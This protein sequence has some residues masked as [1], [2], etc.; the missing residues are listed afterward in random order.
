MCKQKSDWFIAAQTG[1]LEYM[2][3][4]IQKNIQTYDRRESDFEAEIFN[5]FSALHYA[6][7]NRY[8]DLVKLLLPFESTLETKQQVGID[9]PGFCMSGKLRVPPGLNCLQLSVLA[10]NVQIIELIM[11]YLKAEPDVYSV[12]V[13]SCTPYPQFSVFSICAMCG[14]DACIDIML[15]SQFV[16][17]VM[18]DYADDCAPL[19]TATAFGKL[20][21]LQALSQLQQNSLHTK[22]IDRMLLKRDSN[23]MTPI[24]L[25]K[26]PKDPKRFKITD[27]EHNL[28]IETVI[29][30]SKEAFERVKRSCDVNLKQIGISYLQS[31]TEDE[32]FQE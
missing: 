19:F 3:K 8:I 16:Q 25:A 15:N 28:I 14:F 17:E 6:C 21:S 7:F 22:Y 29:K 13:N 20:K 2:K 32:V 23:N 30:M 5:G 31:Q 4:N 9:A 11:N 18:I 1:N 10:G 26:E 27:E 12:F 24:D